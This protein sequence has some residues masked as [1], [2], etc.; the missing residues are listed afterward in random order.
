ML[1]QA[2]LAA[3]HSMDQAVQA[4]QEARQRM[5]HDIESDGWVLGGGWAELK[6]GGQLPNST[7]LDKVILRKHSM[8]FSCDGTQRGV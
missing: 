2:D 1:D 5:N 7:W 3:A 4:V 6:W 8:V